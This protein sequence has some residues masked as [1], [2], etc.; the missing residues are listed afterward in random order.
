MRRDLKSCQVVE[1]LQQ[2]LS[3]TF[4]LKGLTFQHALQHMISTPL[5]TVSHSSSDMLLTADEEQALM[6]V[7]ESFIRSLKKTK[8][9]SEAKEVVDSWVVTDNPLSEWT[10]LQSRGGLIHISQEFN[11]LLLTFERASASVLQTVTGNCNI[12]EL[13]LNSIVNNSDICE[14]FESYSLAPNDDLFYSLAR[15]YSL[16]RCKAYANSIARK[17]RAASKHTKASASLRQ[18]LK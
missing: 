6:Y 15:K 11:R 14:M 3:S 2:G 12:R 10:N 16:V 4:G 8:L 7:G 9:I 17:R 13:V 5:T 18:T 1:R